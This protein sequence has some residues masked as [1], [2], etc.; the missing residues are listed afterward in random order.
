VYP[1]SCRRCSGK[2]WRPPPSKKSRGPARQLT[3]EDLANIAEVEGR[4]KDVAR[5]K[6]QA[7]EKSMAAQREKRSAELMTK[8]L[9]ETPAEHGIYRS[10][11][12]VFMKKD[13][14]HVSDWLSTKLTGCEQKLQVCTTT[15]EYL[16]KQEAQ[17]DTAFLELVKSLNGGRVPGRA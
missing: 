13:R 2:A 15:L 1:S 12:K 9:S 4:V 11:G 3:Q 10:V 6:K 16:G 14:D 8:V 17:A 7:Q 5:Q